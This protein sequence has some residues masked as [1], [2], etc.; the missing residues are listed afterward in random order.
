MKQ[1]DLTDIKN[2]INKVINTPTAEILRSGAIGALGIENPIAGVMA[3]IGDNIY[4]NYNVFKLS[5]LLDGLSTG[6]NRET[7]LNELY[8]Y[9]TSS[10]ENAIAVANLF[11]KTIN[12]ECPK[13][14]CIY[15][16][17]LADH[18]NSNTE[19]AQDELIVCKALENATEFDLKNFKE[20][21][22]NYLKPI[23]DGN[24]IVLPEELGES[25]EFIL[26][27]EWAVYNRL[28]TSRP[29]DGGNIEDE[30]EGLNTQYYES[31]PA[32]VLMKY[33][34][35]ASPIWNYGETNQT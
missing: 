33:I 9:V 26:T 32:F 27:C 22:E 20:I 10:Q 3:G 4:S 28:F 31:K 7:R 11:N 35:E 23:S 2:E 25:N 34:K 1:H 17:I 18:M 14:C 5:R 15:G 8:T 19:F 24:R 6:L 30:Y 12:A 29:T 21:M 13:V 16:L